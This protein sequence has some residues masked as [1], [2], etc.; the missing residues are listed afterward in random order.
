MN[1]NQ[2][3]QWRRSSLY[4]GTQLKPLHIWLRH[5]D[6]WPWKLTYITLKIRTTNSL[7]ER[8]CHLY[9]EQKLIAKGPTIYIY[10][11]RPIL[12]VHPVYVMKTKAG[13][14][15]GQVKHILEKENSHSNIYHLVNYCQDNQSCT[16]L[17]LHYFRTYIIA[18]L[19]TIMLNP[20]FGKTLPRPTIN[21]CKKFLKNS[22]RSC[23]CI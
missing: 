3:C 19:I 20:S 6:G 4:E 22:I 1:S 7:Q 5:Y 2:I 16:R 13:K 14:N 23:K 10:I 11:S 17:I 18:K 15:K 21:C 12:Y 9:Q 8:Q